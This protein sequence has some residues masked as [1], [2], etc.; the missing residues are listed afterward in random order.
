MGHESVGS[1]IGC[2]PLRNDNDDFVVSVAEGLSEEA[3]SRLARVA[4]TRIV[5]KLDESSLIEAVGGSEALL[6]RTYSQITPR[7]IEAAAEAGRLKVIG[8]AGVGVDNIDV[9]AARKA[10]IQ[11]V[12][13][14]AAS[15]DAVAD[16]T[17]GL[18][19]ALQRRIPYSDQQMRA[20]EFKSLRSFKPLPK[21]LRHQTLGVIGMGRIGRAVSQR[22]HLGFGMRI[23]YFDIREVGLLPFVAERQES[24]EA[25]CRRADVVTCH[26]PLTK[27]T[28]GM[29]NESSLRRFRTDAYLINASR[30]PVVDLSA[31]ASALHESRLAG[32]A[33]DV[34]DPEPP[35]LD[36]P[37]F[38]A[39][40]C[41]LTP[42]I[43]ARSA[44]GIAAM[45]D[46]VDDV[47]AVLEGR[48]PT[49]PVDPI[50]Y[51]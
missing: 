14:P 33:L 23:I 25:V 3:I 45:N 48:A 31:L 21:E 43:A 26:V 4:R 32:A 44:E 10:G 42:H 15:T 37:I 20:G 30:G 11:V 19:L 16:L 22:L 7:V 49:Y 13:T 12:H 18:I 38:S 35:P 17:V 34:Y 27:L 9:A 46:V 5:E 6:V 1:G 51:E 39:P 47:I 29:I 24:A 40:N 50:L 8:R 36:H 28:R 41:V 2:E